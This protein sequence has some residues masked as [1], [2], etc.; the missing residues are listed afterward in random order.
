MGEPGTPIWVGEFGPVYAGEDWTDDGRYRVLQDQLDI[1]ER[2]GA[3]WSTWTDK[4]IGLPGLVHADPESP[5]TR[6]LEPVL[7]KEARLGV[8]AWGSLDTARV[9]PL[10]ALRA[11]V[12]AGG[13]PATR[14]GRGVPGLR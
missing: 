8:D 12:Q 11:K 5:W 3:S 13:D 14:G 4:D 1:Y 10:R 7:A 9:V 6:R 2:H